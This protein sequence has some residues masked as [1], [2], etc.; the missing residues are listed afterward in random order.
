MNT[1]STTSDTIAG[2]IA[3]IA[4]A[5]TTVMLFAQLTFADGL[6]DHLTPENINA[7]TQ[8]V[9]KNI[10]DKIADADINIT[11]KLLDLDI[12]DGLNL[13]VKYRYELEPSYSSEGLYT[14]TDKY[15]VNLDL[16]SGD[17]LNVTGDNGLSDQF[18]IGFSIKKG[19][20][21]LFARQFDNQSKAAFA[22]PYSLLQL[23]T[24]AKNALARLNPG[25]FVSIK[26]NLNLAVS[27]Q[28]LSKV[29]DITG[30]PFV[31]LSSSIYYVI[32]GDFQIHIYRKKDNK[33]RMRFFADRK[34]TKGLNAGIN[35]SISSKFELIDNDLA[36]KLATKVTKKIIHFDLNKNGIEVAFFK[37]K[38]DLFILDYELNLSNAAAE[39]AYDDIMARGLKLN[40]ATVRVANPVGSADKL[41]EKLLTDA[42]ALEDLFNKHKGKNNDGSKAD[43]PIERHFKGRDTLKSSGGSFT[44]GLNFVHFKKTSTYTEHDIA[45]YDGNDT[46]TY[47]KF[48]SFYQRAEMKLIAALRK[49]DITQRMTTLL[50]QELDNNKLTPVGF[51][52][53]ALGMTLKDKSLNFKEFES[54][55]IHLKQLLPQ[56]KYNEIIWGGWD[57]FEENIKNAYIDFQVVFTADA[58]DA[59]S[60]TDKNDLSKR[61][62]DY[63]NK[64][65][66]TVL[67]YN[68][69]HTNP[70]DSLAETRRSN[71]DVYRTERNHILNT[72]S[73]VFDKN[74]NANLRV[75]KAMSL[76]KS[77]FFREVGSGL[78]ISLLPQENI[79][80][81]LR[82]SLRAEGSNMELIS[83]TDDNLR[84][85]LYRVVQRIENMVNNRSVDLHLED[86]SL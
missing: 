1:S 50:S 63:L 76:R 64:I 48:N 54:V 6:S 21:I 39:K 3:T 52:E 35:L 70:K 31:N 4:F 36:N 68:D 79:E 26:T 30:S 29:F 23:P 37:S 72:L 7:K 15:I 51:E 41:E 53:L 81:F 56:K 32:S 47:Y 73:I 66:I 33:V 12:V 58:L 74:Q 24:T 2:T 16:A 18:P 9:K 61:I 71:V 55:R 43:R 17:L 82:F 10:K 28:L 27:G 8:K 25:D 11:A 34:R 44:I 14:R 13:A 84:S 75:E 5:V 20:E 45:S 19:A 40:L 67:P 78:L 22:L 57:H 65:T 77:K 62:D 49:K 38:A 42:T 80:R 59:V 60:F 85:E 83:V 86:E 46:P 69:A